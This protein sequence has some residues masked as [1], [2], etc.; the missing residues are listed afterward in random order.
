MESGKVSNALVY[1]GLPTIVGLLMTGFYNFID[2]FFVAQLG[3]SA[4]GAISIAYPFV[5]LIPGISLLFG[6]GGAAYI[7]ELLG[8]GEKKKAEIVLSSTLFC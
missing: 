5:T 6:N 1:L 4:M 3:T 8:A 2:S 7:S